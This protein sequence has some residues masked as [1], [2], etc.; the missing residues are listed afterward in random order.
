[1]QHHLRC[2]ELWQPVRRSDVDQ[3]RWRNAPG[4]GSHR[5]T[6]QR[7]GGHGGNAAADKAFVPRDAGLVERAHRDGADAAGRGERRERQGI[8]AWP[9]EALCREPAELVLGELLAAAAAAF[10]AH[11]HGVELAGIIGVEYLS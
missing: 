1:M 2:A 9:D 5:E 7:G 8:A 6:S 10:L 4:E 3:P 11:D